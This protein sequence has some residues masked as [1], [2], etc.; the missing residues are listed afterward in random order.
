MSNKHNPAYGWQ[1]RYRE[2][3]SSSKL[4]VAYGSNLN[5]D[6]MKHRCPTA[7]VVGKSELKGYKMT[8]RG[9]LHGGVATVEP[10]ENFS[11]PVLVWRIYP[12]DE[13]FLDSYEG[14]P[15]LYRKETCQVEVNG[16]TVDAMIYIMNDGYHVHRPSNEY[17]Q[18]ILEGYESAGFDPEILKQYAYA[19]PPLDEAGESAEDGKITPIIRRQILAIRDSG[20]TNMFDVKTVQYLAYHRDFYELVWF[21]EEHKD[22]YVRFILTGSED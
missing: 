5:L 3:R 18:T 20:E 19:N 4:Y 8:F 6:Q 13:R 7:E 22:K 10:D 16:E 1:D 21:L 14:V 9:T 2:A 12:I 11:V 15:R 17:Y